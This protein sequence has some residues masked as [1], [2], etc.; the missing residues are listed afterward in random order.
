MVEMD[1]D[2]IASRIRRLATLSTRIGQRWRALDMSPDAITARVE[3]L[4][5]SSNLCAKLVE[6][7]RATRRTDTVAD[8]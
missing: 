7:G 2:A 1:A 3:V 8:P 4:A 6:L 5:A